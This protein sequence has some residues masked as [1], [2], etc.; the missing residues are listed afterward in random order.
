MST[1]EHRAD[2]TIA[3]AQALLEKIQADFAQ[4][5]EFFRSQGLDP[6][7]VRQ[8]GAAALGQREQEEVDRLLREDRE[9][10][11]RE[12]DEAAARARFESAPVGGSPR[13]PR[14]LV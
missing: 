6:E 1:T 11:D 13:K 7:K 10:I 3:Q 9:A 2:Q 5:A 12:V 8:V 4:S 14:N